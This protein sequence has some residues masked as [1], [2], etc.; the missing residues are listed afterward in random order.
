MAKIREDELDLLLLLDLQLAPFVVQ[1][2]NGERFNEDGLAAAGLIV[3]DARDLRLVFY[4]DRQAVAA[5]PHGHDGILQIAAVFKQQG[6]QLGMDA[7]GNGPQLTPDFG[8][9]RTGLVS[10]LFLAQDIGLQQLAEKRKRCQ[11]GETGRKAVGL[12]PAFLAAVG[13][14]LAGHGQ[15]PFDIQQFGDA[16]RGAGLGPLYGGADIADP[17]KA[18]VAVGNEAGF[19][20]ARFL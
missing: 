20:I 4:L 13:L 11:T 10:D 9:A 16:Q 17:G 19:G 18:G 2:D 8:Q 14:C 1:P 6:I 5:V 12:V 15:K 7:V 3:N